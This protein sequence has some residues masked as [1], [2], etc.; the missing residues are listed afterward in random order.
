M[1]LDILG[2]IYTPETIAALNRYREHLGGVRE[3]LEERQA[4]AREGLKGYEDVEAGDGSV[5]DTGPMG[6][7]A[8]RY[9]ELARE[10]E[11][12]KMEIRRLA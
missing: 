3:R 2:Q 9:G 6:E 11:T 10:V 4:L 7:I 12:V 8:R 1:K 5:R